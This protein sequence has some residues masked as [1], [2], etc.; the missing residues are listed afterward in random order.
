MKRLLLFA[1]LIGSL[2]A[3]AQLTAPSVKDSIA[4]ILP[5]SRPR[6]VTPASIRQAIFQVVDFA[7]TLTGIVGP[8]GPQ[9]IQG[10]VGP[11]GIQGATGPAGPQGVPGTP[12]NLSLYAKKDTLPNFVTLA[13]TQT[14]T[15]AKTFS[16]AIK[17]NSSV[18]DI[19][20][21]VT[22]S[23]L[24]LGLFAQNASGAFI[25]TR[26][27]GGNLNN[28]IRGYGNNEFNISYGNTLFGSTTDSGEKIQVTGTS[29]FTGL[30]N[31]AGGI[32]L[33]NGTDWTSYNTV[34][35]TTNYERVR[36]AWAS[37]IYTIVLE[38]GG[39][40]GNR[41]LQFYGNN[42]LLLTAPN[43]SLINGYSTGNPGSIVTLNTTN[44]ASAGTSSFLTLNTNVNQSGTA[45]YKGIWATIYEQSLGSGEKILLDLG[46]NSAANG[47]GTHTSKYKVDNTGKSTQT[48]A[49]ELTTAGE[50][51]ILKTPDGTKRYKITIDNSGNLITT[52]L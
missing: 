21:D 34:D 2:T 28:R 48:G 35:E 38:K 11:Q 37:N 24:N 22:R 44:S 39:T 43:I 30:L 40:G 52:L 49:A 10:P 6:V 45:N 42:S 32:K 3:Q 19:G 8:A 41:S 18:N 5:D 31:A 25:E 46:T 33:P 29:K 12:A 17:V 47:S 15:G 9:G 1:L 26:Q 51:V 16:G 13:G 36:G 4:K 50:G 20:F 23:G 27:I 14:I 7:D